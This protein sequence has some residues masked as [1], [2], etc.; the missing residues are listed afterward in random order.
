MLPSRY[1]SDTIASGPLS[2]T[3]SHLPPPTPPSPL[4]KLSRGGSLEEEVDGS[5][6]LLDLKALLSEETDLAIEHQVT[7]PYP[8]PTP[9]YP[10]VPHRTP[11]YPA[12]PHPTPP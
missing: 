4:S 3:L 6:T 7:P 5:L 8:N 2:D 12:L 1:L 11:P 9:P 10:T